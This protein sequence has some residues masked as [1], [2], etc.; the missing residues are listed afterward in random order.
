[1]NR[2]WSAAMRTT[3][4]S[5]V[6]NPPA[7]SNRKRS[8]RWARS[9]ATLPTSSGPT[10]TRSST[11]VPLFDPVIATRCAT[12]ISCGPDVGRTRANG[13]PGYYSGSAKTAPFSNDAAGP[14]KRPSTS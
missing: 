6:I 9:R 1:M 14:R 5:R 7:P 8:R 3:T 10:T 12:A 13:G 11:R 4:G 2:R